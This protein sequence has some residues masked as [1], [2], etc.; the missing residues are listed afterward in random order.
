MAGR[1]YEDLGIGQKFR[2]GVRR[3]GDRQG[4]QDLLKLAQMLNIVHYIAGYP[5]EPVDLHHS[6]RHLEATYDIL[7]MTDKGLHCYSL[8]RQRNR[9]ALEMV[10]I[11]RGIDMATLDRE[12][13]VITVV[14]TNSPLRLD[15][16]MA[17]GMMEFAAHN[18][19]IV[20]TPFTLAGARAPITWEVKY[21]ERRQSPLITYHL[22][23]DED[24]KGPFVAREFLSWKR[25]SHGR[26][27]NFLDFGRDVP[28]SGEVVTGEMPD[29]EDTRTDHRLAPPRA[30]GGATSRRPG[31]A[32]SS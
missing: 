11:A 26:P 28:G 1:Y 8:G 20:V 7:T 5:V 22:E 6:I 25:G 32:T 4:F 19:P 31:G 10:R 18:Q 15:V 2:H 17:Q 16:P 30:A 23:I 12:P 27:F 14:N 29:E 24:A 3:T 9:D 13:S 21:R